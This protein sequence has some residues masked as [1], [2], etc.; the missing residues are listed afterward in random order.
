M[1]IVSLQKIE[2]IKIARQ[3]CKARPFLPPL[4]LLVLSLFVLCFHF[5][6]LFWIFF[7][8]QILFGQYG[9]GATSGETTNGVSAQ[10]INLVSKVI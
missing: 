6:N 3:K 4:F 5:S 8:E 1:E 2:K 9:T 7:Q 10:Q